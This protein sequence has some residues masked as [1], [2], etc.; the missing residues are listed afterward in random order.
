MKKILFTAMFIAL[1]SSESSYAWTLDA[2]A[3]MDQVYTPSNDQML[4]NKM[5]PMHSGIYNQRRFKKNWPSAGIVAPK[6]PRKK[7]TPDSMAVNEEIKLSH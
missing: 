5:S 3:K 4:I 7:T 6:K 1:A 2:E